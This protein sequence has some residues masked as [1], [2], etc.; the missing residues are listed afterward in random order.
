VTDY[1]TITHDGDHRLVRFERQYNATPEEVWAALTEPDQLAGWLAQASLEPRAGGRVHLRWTTG[2]EMDGSIT[3]FEPPRLLEYTWREPADTQPS[4][5]RFELTTAESGTRLVLEH[6]KLPASGAAG[7]GAGWH[8]HLDALR[9]LLARPRC[10]W[11]TASWRCG[12][13]SPSDRS[14]RLAS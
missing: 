2:D 10:R 1:G 9:A 11:P 13:P 5:V 3:V 12:W 7:F 8:S 4:V 6:R 14:W